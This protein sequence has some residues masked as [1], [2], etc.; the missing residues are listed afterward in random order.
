MSVALL[1][2]LTEVSFCG[3]HTHPRHRRGS[4][5]AYCVFLE[6]EWRFQIDISLEHVRL[7]GV[8]FVLPRLETQ[9]ASS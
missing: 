1:L 4:A 7:Y 6:R 8:C 3:G 5:F 9:S 2:S